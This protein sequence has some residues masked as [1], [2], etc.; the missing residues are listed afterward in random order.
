MI[1]FGELGDGGLDHVAIGFETR[2]HR[3]NIA[4]VTSRASLY[5]QRSSVATTQKGRA[6][7]ETSS[8]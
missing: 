4:T 8:V 5:C 6:S 2:L 7:T 3:Y 1:A